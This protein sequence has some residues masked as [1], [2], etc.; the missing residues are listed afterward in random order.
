MIPYVSYTTYSI[1]GLTFQVWGTFVAVGFLVAS[2][3]VIRRAR[4]LGL[5]GRAVTDLLFWV[6]IAAFIGARAFHVLF[7][8]PGYYLHHP[9]EAIDPRQPGYAIFGG[10][11]GAFL[12]FWFI[13]KKRGLDL[14]AYADAL[15]WGVPWGCGIGRIGCFLIHDHPGT[16]SHFFLATRTAEGESRHDLG[17]YLSLVGFATGVLFLILNQKKRRGG[18]WIGTLMI[19]V[20]T[21]RFFLD[22]LRIVDTRYGWLTPAQILSLPL[23]CFGIY[24]LVRPRKRFAG[25]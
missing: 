25:S 7:Y 6:F 17:L 5:D 12:A 10:Y 3:I 1:F 8:E 2:W 23:V 21:S 22:F 24:V 16:L 18:F 19:V 11:I 4:R 9:L 14:I 20:G 15:A 13:V